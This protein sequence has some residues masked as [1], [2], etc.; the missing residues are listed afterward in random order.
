MAES[1]SGEGE[2]KKS[3]KKIIIIVV[4]VVLLLAGGGAGY[5]FMAGN[6]DAAEGEQVEDG[7]EEEEE[8]EEE[9][10]VVE[11]LYYD[12]NQPLI[13]T[14]P[15]GSMASL[16]QVSVSVLAKGESTVEA[17]KKHEPMIRSN[18]LMAISA[19]EAKKLITR[20]GKEELRS[21][22]LD[23]VG[24]V[25]ERMTGKNKVKN[26]FFTTFVMQ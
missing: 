10:G 13:V 5:Y 9:E 4:A 11:D 23:E 8:D 19:N 25:M 24:K 1:E 16:I 2:D 20:E 21:I 15:K 17:L 14:F 22:M 7:Q 6:P 18:L 12:L 26:I 3:S